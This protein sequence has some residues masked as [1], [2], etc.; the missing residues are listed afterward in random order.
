MNDAEQPLPNAV[1]DRSWMWSLIGLGVVLAAVGGL[2]VAGVFTPLLDQTV[3]RGR[4]VQSL[5]TLEGALAE[6]RALRDANA[7]DAEWQAAAVSIQ[8]RVQPMVD[9]LK[10]TASRKYPAKQMLLWAARDRLPQVLAA[11]RVAGTHPEE[12][13]E[14]LL[15]EAARILDVPASE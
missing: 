9:D 14:N 11:G 5:R 13:L 1:P 2:F 15:W 4:D 6:I 10:R 7:T 3:G 12:E 8:T